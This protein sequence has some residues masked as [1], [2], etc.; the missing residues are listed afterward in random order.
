LVVNMRMPYSL[1]TFPYPGLFGDIVYSFGS[2]L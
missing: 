2:C 1:L